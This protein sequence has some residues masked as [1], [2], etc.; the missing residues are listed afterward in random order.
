MHIEREIAV[1][2][3]IH[4]IRRWS[5]KAETMRREVSVDGIRAA[6]KRRRAQRAVVVAVIVIAKPHDVAP[7]HGGVCHQMK[8]EIDGLGVLQMRHAGHERGGVRLCKR[9]KRIEQREQQLADMQIF[10]QHIEPKV[11]RDLVVART[12]RVQLFAHIA[13]ARNQRRFDCHVNVFVRDVEHERAALNLR[14]NRFEPLDN[15]ARFG[16]GE[17]SLIGEHARMNLAALNVLGV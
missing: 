14:G 3:G 7:K 4:R 9:H 17:D 15:R 2:H 13:N 16:I 6:R 10:L 1:A 5:D 8:A 11:E 12:R